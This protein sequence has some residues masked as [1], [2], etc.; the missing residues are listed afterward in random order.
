MEKGF[1]LNGLRH[2]VVT[3][4]AEMGYDERTIADVLGQK[5]IETAR[6][7]ARSA[8]KRI[9]VGAAVVRFEDIMNKKST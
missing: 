6:H 1:I 7:Y 8:D 9:K 2:T 5:T 3:S 4:L